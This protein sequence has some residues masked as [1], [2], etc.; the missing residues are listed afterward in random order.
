MS[1][2]H[3][4]ARLASPLGDL[5]AVVDRAERLVQLDFVDARS[6]AASERELESRCARRGHSLAWEPRALAHV[7]AALERWFEGRLFAF[8]LALAPAGTPFQHAVWDALRRVPYGATTSYGELA[9]AIGRPTAARAVG[10]AN[11]SNPIAI[12][13]PCHRAIG[14]SGA[15]TGY[16]G[17]LERKRALLAL[18]RAAL[19]SCTSSVALAG[20]GA[21]LGAVS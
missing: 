9:R 6:R 1:S 20:S 10:R 11:G 8:E 21:A 2:T 19:R 5:F 18:E 15:L 16:A 14:T 3:A 13:V 17:G 12:V 7:A 4:A